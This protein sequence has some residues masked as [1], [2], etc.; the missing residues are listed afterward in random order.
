MLKLILKVYRP[1]NTKEIIKIIKKKKNF[2]I[3]G[4]G[5]SYGDVSLNFQ[6]LIKTEK[7]TQ[8]TKF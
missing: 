7:L 2:T 4:N 3:Q 1:E 6:N 8:D 5:R